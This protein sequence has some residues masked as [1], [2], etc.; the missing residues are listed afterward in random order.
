[1]SVADDVE[2]ALAGRDGVVAV[3]VGIELLAATL[4]ARRADGSGRWRVACPPGVV[5]D[6]G[7]A[8][9]LGSAAAE[10]CARGT[11]ALR[12]GTGPRPDRTLFASAGRVDAVVGPADD[13]TLLTDAESDRTTAAAEA[14]EARF[15]AAAPAS[16]GMPSRSR[17]LSAARE[18]LDDRFAADLET[19]LSTL[20][21]DPTA[22]D[23]SEALDDRT[24]LVA[25]A[26][27]HDHLFA[28]VRE[29]ADDVGIAPK[30]TFSAARRA[31]EERGL[32]ESIKVPMG[33]GR[34]NYRL[35]AVDE[36]LNRVDAVRFPSA[37]RELF[38][39][40]D[41]RSGSGIGGARIDDRP[42]WDRRR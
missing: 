27:R 15:E 33:I 4:S 12:T 23:R 41:A 39:A 2:A 40:A 26:A 3:G 16:I 35:R 38:E 8:L 31:L 6:L 14:V 1:M 42:V 10:A 19:V 11:I 24:L 9:A 28:D 22:L 17:L 20:G 37:L 21:T 25:L 32:V 29:W 18:A 7:R 30:Q 5:D 13:R 36:T 34:P